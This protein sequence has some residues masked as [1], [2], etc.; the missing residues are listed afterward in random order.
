MCR[1]VD[2]WG[3]EWS[4]VCVVDALFFLDARVRNSESLGAG[5]WLVQFR[6]S[7]MRVVAYIFEIGVSR[8]L[9]TQVV[10]FDTTPLV[11]AS[12]K[13]R[14]RACLYSKSRRLSLMFN[15]S[16]SKNVIMD[17]LTEGHKGYSS[18]VRQLQN[19]E[20]AEASWRTL[21][22]SSSLVVHW[23]ESCYHGLSVNVGFAM[24][25]RDLV[26]VAYFKPTVVD[27]CSFILD[28]SK[29][30]VLTVVVYFSRFLFLSQSQQ[31]NARNPLRAIVFSKTLLHA[32]CF[33]GA[34]RRTRKSVENAAK[35]GKL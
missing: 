27:H 20:Y 2:T 6:N 29:F 12:G 1:I 16:G 14:Q 4:C 23:D 32:F 18:K 26:T 7:L 9:E 13:R 17:C 21:C 31:G 28:S 5:H 15:K 8:L 3:S 11:V 33:V 34:E 35:A 10:D 24:D 25:T 19:V 30:H 22:P